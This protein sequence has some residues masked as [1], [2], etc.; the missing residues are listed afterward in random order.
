MAAYLN[1][2]TFEEMLTRCGQH[3]NYEGAIVLPH[4][5]D[6]RAFT[7]EMVRLNSLERIP[8]F[9][10][11]RSTPRTSVVR[12]TNG[13]SLEFTTAD[14]MRNGDRYHSVLVHSGICHP[15]FLDG[16]CRFEKP[17]EADVFRDAVYAWQEDYLRKQRSFYRTHALGDWVFEPP[18]PIDP[19][20]N[21]TDTEELD[22]FLNEF[23]V[24]S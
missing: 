23:A 14:D 24:K 19:M 10:D 22:N 2:T 9:R 8:F 12:F 5:N 18:K 11:V 20:E 13:S 3:S 21:V 15:E 1:E 6:V 7:E 16:I 4:I 17:Y